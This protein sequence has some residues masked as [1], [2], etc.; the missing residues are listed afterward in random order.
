[1]SLAL[2]QHVVVAPDVHVL[3]GQTH[4][5]LVHVSPESQ[6]VPL[7]SGPGQHLVWPPSVYVRSSGHVA[8]HAPAPLFFVLSQKPLQQAAS[9]EHVSPR[10]LLSARQ[11][12][13]SLPLAPTSVASH[14][15]P[16]AQQ[17]NP[18]WPSP[19]GH[20]GRHW[21]STVSK[22]AASQVAQHLVLV[23]P[24][25][26]S[27]M[28]LQQSL[29]GFAP[30]V[31]VQVSPTSFLPD[32]QHLPRPPWTGAAASQISVLWQVLTPHLQVPL[33]VSQVSP[34]F[35]QPGVPFVQHAVFGM[36]AVPHSFDELLHTQM[37][38]LQTWFVPH[39]FG[40]YEHV[41]S[42][43]VAP[44]TTSHVPGVSQSVASRQ[45]THVP[46]LAA[47]TQNGVLPPRVAQ[48]TGVASESLP[49]QTQMPVCVTQTLPPDN[50]SSEQSVSYAH[51]SAQVPSALQYRLSTS[52]S[53]QWLVSRHSTHVPSLSL[54]CLHH[55]SSPLQAASESSSPQ[56]QRCG[57]SEVLQA[58]VARLLGHSTEL[59]QPSTQVLA[60]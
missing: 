24:C 13:P 20:G 22:P 26:R 1:M 6:Q 57:V 43:Q 52:S 23:S 48:L 25:L 50:G 56:T 38:P 21:P 14:R 19:V 49:W 18:Q 30:P 32:A 8:T 10:I 11:H 55:G 59:R 45:A 54:V 58:L 15:R 2:G 36:Q 29:V 4:W 41:P 40:G 44:S 27:Q 47:P 39:G 17:L 35:V 5:L 51:P 42:L 34:T 9:L 53:R 16:S 37:S 31:T 46:A 28:P 33:L 7:H 60:S 3:V 12:L